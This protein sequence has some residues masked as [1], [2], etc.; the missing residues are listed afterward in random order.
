M[1]LPT[2]ITFDKYGHCVVCHSNMLIEEVIDGKLQKRFTPDYSETEYLLNDGSRMRVAI[3]LACKDKIT[4]KDSEGIMNCVI[5]GW[6]N[7][8]ADFK[9]WSDERKKNYLDKF[10]KK[11]IVCRSEHVPDDVLDNKLKD[12]KNKEKTDG[13][14]RKDIHL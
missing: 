6:E 14:N 11:K 2:G 4:D 3:C 5:R 10:S 7:E 13:L 1:S 12:Y 8:V 9:H